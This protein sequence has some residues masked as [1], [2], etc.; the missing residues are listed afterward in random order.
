MVLSKQK[1]QHAELFAFTICAEN[2]LSEKHVVVR[3]AFSKYNWFLVSESAIL[4]LVVFDLY[5]KLLRFFEDD[6][7]SM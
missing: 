4:G 6:T 2:L 1:V 7:Q 3:T 5:N